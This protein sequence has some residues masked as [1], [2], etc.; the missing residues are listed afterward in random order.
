MKIKK[1]LFVLL[2]CAVLVAGLSLSLAGCPPDDDDDDFFR[3]AR[4]QVDTEQSA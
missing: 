3:S 1:N 4:V 2:G